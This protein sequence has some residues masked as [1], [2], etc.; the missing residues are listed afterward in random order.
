MLGNVWEWCNDWFDSD[1]YSSSPTNNP[2]GPS[3]GSYHVVRG[4]SWVGSADYCCSI[5]GRGI[6]TPSVCS[7]YYIG[8]SYVYGESD[9]LVGF[10][11]ASSGAQ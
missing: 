6:S 4:G 5:R 11:C 9:Q 7:V 8:V 10:R 1:Y 2:Q 3:S